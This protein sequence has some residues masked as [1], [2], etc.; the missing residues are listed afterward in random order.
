MKGHSTGFAIQPVI[1]Q[2]QD[3]DGQVQVR[4]DKA[5]YRVAIQLV[6][7]GRIHSHGVRDSRVSLG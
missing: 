7:V 4:D 1:E 2:M 3:W 5:S 6:I